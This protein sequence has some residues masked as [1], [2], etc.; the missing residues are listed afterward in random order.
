MLVL[1]WFVMFL[2]RREP[3][4][5]IWDHSHGPLYCLGLL[6]FWLFLDL[7]ISGQLMSSEFFLSNKMLIPSYLWTVPFAFHGE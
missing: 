6:N 2:R 3:R 5:E 4:T 7:S 1:A